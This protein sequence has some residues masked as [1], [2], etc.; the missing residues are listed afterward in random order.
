[1]LVQVSFTGGPGAMCWV[2]RLAAL[3]TVSESIKDS[4]S[5]G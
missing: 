2:V 3:N 1:M 4:Y 5:V